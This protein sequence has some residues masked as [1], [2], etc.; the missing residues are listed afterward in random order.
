MP[1]HTLSLELYEGESVRAVRFRYGLL[2]FDLLTIIYLAITLFV[3]G[4]PY[5]NSS[6]LLLG[7]AYSRS[8]LPAYGSAAGL[9][10]TCF[11]RSASLT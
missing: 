2:L 10:M 6:T 4:A 9:C 3:G 8:S 1:T 5:S 11:T 7:S